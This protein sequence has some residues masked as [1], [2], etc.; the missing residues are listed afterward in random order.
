MDEIYELKEEI[1]R[2]RDIVK[3]K[4]KGKVRLKWWSDIIN[5][6]ERG[7]D[8]ENKVEEELIEKIEK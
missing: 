1:E 2:I 3:E 8:E 5:G 6:E 7:S 4:I